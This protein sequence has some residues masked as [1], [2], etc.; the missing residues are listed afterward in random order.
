MIVTDGHLGLCESYLEKYFIG[1]IDNDLWDEEEVKK[2]REYCEDIPECTTCPYY[3]QC[4]RLKICTE[5]NACFKEWR[6]DNIE[7]IRQQML[8]EYK[9]IKN[10]ENTV[11]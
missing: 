9:S 3:P 2:S 7:T 8:D 5:H 6:E 10:N 4:F 11:L 1:H